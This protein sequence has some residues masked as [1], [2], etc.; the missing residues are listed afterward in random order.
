MS[1]RNNKPKSPLQAY[2]PILGLLLA[3]ALGILAWAI[4]PG[5]FDWLGTWLRGFPPAGVPR[6]TLELIITVVIF[7]VLGLLAGL[8]VA[9]GMPKKKSAVSEKDVAVARARMV[10]E[11]RIRKLRQKQMNKERNR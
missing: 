2:W 11:K 1:M 7:L 3:I 9:L 10:E 4:A 6:R 5:A 8:L